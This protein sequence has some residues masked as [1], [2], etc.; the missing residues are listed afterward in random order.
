MKTSYDARRAEMLKLLGGKCSKCGFQDA[1]ALEVCP[2]ERTPKDWGAGWWQ[3]LK[4]VMAEPDSYTLRCRNCA[5]IESTDGH[6]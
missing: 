1:R 3:K 2:K 4:S 6:P 5:R